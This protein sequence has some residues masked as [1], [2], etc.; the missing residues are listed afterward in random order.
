MQ[1]QLCHLVASRAPV[2]VISTLTFARAGHYDL[3]RLH[4]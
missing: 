1:I 3:F 2:F 4:A